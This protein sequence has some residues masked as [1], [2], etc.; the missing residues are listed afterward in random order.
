MADTKKKMSDNS[1]QFQ[2][3]GSF[4]HLNRNRVNQANNITPGEFLKDR[5]ELGNLIKSLQTLIETSHKEF[6]R[7]INISPD[8][9]GYINGTNEVQKILDKATD[10]NSAIVLLPTK[11]AE[12]KLKSD[13][14]ITGAKTAKEY[15]DTYN[16]HKNIIDEVFV[17]ITNVTKKLNER[18]EKVDESLYQ[19]DLNYQKN[20]EIQTVDV[21]KV[22]EEYLENAK[23]KY[24]A[25]DAATEDLTDTFRTC[26]RI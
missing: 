18:L 11:I 5:I 16:D 2:L 19:I 25:L 15:S 8:Q 17:N 10:I 4:E 6:R 26:I 1:S 23:Q 7:A 21:S 24:R 22:Y 13:P 14:K 20:N 3:D 12:I 9:Q